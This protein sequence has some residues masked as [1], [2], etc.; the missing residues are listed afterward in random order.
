MINLISCL[1]FAKLAISATYTIPYSQ[2][3]L[4]A[5]DI[6]PT[7]QKCLQ[8]HYTDNQSYFSPGGPGYTSITFKQC[9]PVDYS[10]ST[11]VYDASLTTQNAYRSLNAIFNSMNDDCGPVNG[12]FAGCG[13]GLQCIHYGAKYQCVPFVTKGFPTNLARHY[14]TCGASTL[15]KLA[16]DAPHVCTPVSA[17]IKG[18]VTPNGK[19]ICLDANG[20]RKRLTMQRD[21]PFLFK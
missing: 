17:T 13:S 9:L 19:N 20:L 10:E 21:A 15:Q 4:P 16:C 18:V 5:T 11:M 6:C 2:C 3:H 8:L 12:A 7:G 1:V 14:Q